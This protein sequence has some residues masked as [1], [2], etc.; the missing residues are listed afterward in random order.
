MDY[1]GGFYISTSKSDDRL[2]RLSNTPISDDDTDFQGFSVSLTVSKIKELIRKLGLKPPKLKKAELLQFLIGNAQ[3]PEKRT[4]RKTKPKTEPKPKAEEQVIP[5]LDKVSSVEPKKKERPPPVITKKENLVDSIRKRQKEG[6]TTKS[7]YKQKEPTSAELRIASL[8]R[9]EKVKELSDEEKALRYVA[10]EWPRLR[11]GEEYYLPLEGLDD[12][13][14]EP[15]IQFIRDSA[16]SGKKITSGEVFN[17]DNFSR[18]LIKE[19]VKRQSFSTIDKGIRVIM[20]KEGANYDKDSLASYVKW[21]SLFGESE[22]LK[23]EMKSKSDDVRDIMTGIIIDKSKPKPEP[24]PKAKA[25]PKPEPKPKS[26]SKPKVK[27]EPKTTKKPEIEEDYDDISNTLQQL[28]FSTSTPKMANVLAKL[29]F[30]GRLQS[31]P[32]LKAMQILQNFKTIPQ[33]KQLIN[34]INE[35]K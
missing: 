22:K 27:P 21:A 9:G 2:V 23:K 4:E 35:E 14:G 1:K 15:I 25:K 31:N 28:I 29:N 18:K 30:K 8:I 20:D 11:E 3:Q 33:M 24:K 12:D 32:M 19:L 5:P 13:L 34:K 10:K 17:I 16:K 7:S 26:E 6:K